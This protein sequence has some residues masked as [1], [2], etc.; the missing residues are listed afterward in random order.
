MVLS[1]F[2]NNEREN[3]R[4]ALEIEEQQKKFIRDMIAEEYRRLR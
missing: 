2:V 1:S 4:H 3:L